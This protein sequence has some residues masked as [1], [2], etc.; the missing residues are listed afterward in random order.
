MEANH[1][2]VRMSDSNLPE[3]AGRTTKS[4]FLRLP[5]DLHAVLSRQAKRKKI[6]IQKVIIQKIDQTLTKGK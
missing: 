1:S 4:V 3:T 2:E 5:A 6:T